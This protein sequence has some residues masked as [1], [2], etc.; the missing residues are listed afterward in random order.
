MRSINK[1]QSHLARRIKRCLRKYGE[2]DA[3]RKKVNFVIFGGALS[4]ALFVSPLRRLLLVTAAN[5][6]TKTR[7][8]VALPSSPFILC[9][10]FIH[11]R[12][13]L[14]HCKLASALHRPL[15]ASNLECRDVSHG[16]QLPLPHKLKQSWLMLAWTHC[17]D[18]VQRRL[19]C[20]SCMLIILQVAQY[21]ILAVLCGSLSFLHMRGGRSDG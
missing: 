18:N 9:V 14:K 10:L 17:F 4:P 3:G 19:L 1:G 8:R 13:S 21:H 6:I 7:A 12:I 2:N 11:R 15:S 5:L 20:L 16:K